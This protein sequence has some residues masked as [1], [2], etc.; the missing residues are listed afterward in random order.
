MSR[1]GAAAVFQEVLPSESVR[2]GVPSSSC[3]TGV[4]PVGHFG[5]SRT[6]A[7]TLRGSNTPSASVSIAAVAANVPHLLMKTVFREVIFTI[8]SRKQHSGAKLRKSPRTRRNTCFAQESRFSKSPSR[9]DEDPLRIG[10]FYFAARRVTT[11]VNVSAA[12]IEW[13]ENQTGPAWH[14]FRH[15]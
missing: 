15:W 12:G 4:L 1:A 7:L 8:R 9:H 13:I 3:I 2:P 5:P 6:Y 14:R 10:I 11:H